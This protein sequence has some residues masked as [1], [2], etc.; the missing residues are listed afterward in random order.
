VS[1]PADSPEAARLWVAFYDELIETET[2]ALE[3]MRRLA[4]DLP[5][6]ERRQLELNDIEPMEQVVEE[7]RTRRELWR[8][9][10]DTPS[11]RDGV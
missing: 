2:R 3:L 9:V 5:A 1:A 6:S 10:G 7:W 8:G 4:S 11:S